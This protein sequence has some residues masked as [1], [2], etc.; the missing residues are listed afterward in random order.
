VQRH[1]VER[2]PGLAVGRRRELVP[3]AL[4]PAAV[5]AEHL[6]VA[7]RGDDV[8]QPLA[9]QLLRRLARRL[10]Q[11][12]R[13]HLDAQVSVEHHD[14]RLRYR[15][16]QHPIARGGALMPPADAAHLDL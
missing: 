16:Q 4:Q 10:H 13:D 8:G 11:A 9:H 5:M 2:E 15:V 1:H 3:L 12:A 6:G 7:L 14:Q